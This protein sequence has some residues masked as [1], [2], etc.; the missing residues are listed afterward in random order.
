MYLPYV[1]D[2][3]PGTGGVLRATI[4]DFVVEEL[5]AYTPCGDG[6][7]VYA[8]I[9]KRGLSTFQVVETLARTL[10]V[11]PAD[12]G[13]AGL[14]DR[15]AVTRQFLSFPPP[16]TP[17]RVRALVLEG[18]DILEVDRHRNKLRTGHLRGN[19]FRIRVRGGQV[20]AA[21]AARAI[22]DRLAEAPG[23]PNWFGDQRFG[24]RGDNHE[25]GRALVTGAALARPPRGRQRRLYISAF[26]S[27]LFN[28]YL[29]RRIR[30]HRYRQ[31]LAGDLLRG[32]VA[33]GPIFGHKMRGPEPDSEAGRWEASILDEAAVTVGD[34][35]RVG[36]LAEGTRRPI[37]VALEAPEV[38][39]L[40]DREF[41]I[42][43][44]LPAGA[45]AT[46]VL[47]EIVKPAPDDQA[48][49]SVP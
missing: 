8:W 35:A 15:H 26:Q 37:A 5:P 25:V 22:V 33:T 9:E 19:R 16:V 44:A 39:A 36:K 17:E 30:E 47:R 32:A 3:L 7:H 20:G 21:A 24:A 2:D 23:S 41:E 12:I 48:I 46:S 13:T 40:G 28:Q 4:D 31:P 6:D 49:R 42:R 1:T 29:S 18:V 45:Y 11:R 43:F 10:D 14:K 38:I 27:H 34:F